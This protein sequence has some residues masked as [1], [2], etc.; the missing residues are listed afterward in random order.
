MLEK[1]AIRNWQAHR[2]LRIEFDARVTAIVGATD[3]GKSAIL[4]AIRW[5]LSNRPRGGSFITQG[6]DKT[7]ITV[8]LDGHRIARV[9]SASQNKY[10]FDGDEFVSFGAGVPDPIESLANFDGLNYQAQHDAAFWL[11]CTPSDLSKRLNELVDLSLI[12]RVLATTSK[13]QRRCDAKAEV[14]AD[15]LAEASNMCRGLEW[16]PEADQALSQIEQVADEVDRLSDRLHGLK[17]ILADLDDLDQ[18]A[19]MAG[20]GSRLADIERLASILSSRMRSV[21][22]L[23]AALADVSACRK[24]LL[25]ARQEALAADA[26]IARIPRCSAC[27]QIIREN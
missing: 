12:D 13:R 1:I 21:G 15:Q 22:L 16:V 17:A 3:S 4:R 26:E 14:L 2:D 27:G 19:R 20:D 23:G 25:A 10:M 7:A 24:K 6:E 11:A 18:S 9:K 5:V 8:W